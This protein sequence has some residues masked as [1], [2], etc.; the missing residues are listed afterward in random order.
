MRVVG[1]DLSLTSTGVAVIE[2]R[3]L[4]AVAN[5]TSAGRKGAS[6]VDRAKRLFNIGVEVE[7]LLE[8][9]PTLV[10]VEGPA[11]MSQV[12]AMHD[13]SGLWWQIVAAVYLRCD[14]VAEVAPK[15]RAKYLTGDGNAKKD[16]VLAHAIERYVVGGG[17]RIPNHDIADAVGLADMGA[18]YL[19]ISPVWDED[20]PEDNLK[21]M[22][23]VR[24]PD[25]G[26]E[27]VVVR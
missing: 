8:P 25:M 27:T 17:P 9:A 3:E 7:Q 21:A 6:L 2:D 19:G 22:S 1:L 13:R 24:W 10:V 5:I 15:T 20:M 12:G 16:V 11:F 4:V 26:P 18:R 23:S 14:Y